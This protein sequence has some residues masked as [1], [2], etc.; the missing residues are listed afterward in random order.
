M[1]KLFPVFRAEETANFYDFLNAHTSDI[2]SCVSSLRQT[3]HHYCNEEMEKAKVSGQR[4]IELEK[5]ADDTRRKAEEALYEGV[6]IPFGRE[7]KYELLEA[8]DDLADKAEI[9]VR[10][11]AIEK[12]MIPPQLRAD[13]K[14]LANQVEIAT[15]MLGESVEKLGTDIKEA[16]KTATKVE[17]IRETARD[18]E[19]DILEH[20]LKNPIDPLNTILLKELITLVA[21]VADKAEDAA[22]R[23]ITLA[24]KY[25]S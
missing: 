25:K 15:N 23:V 17:L 6:I 8:L 12:P 2:K 10:L 11:A 18:H 21:K 1:V 3:V 7:D 16:I 13:I 20:L 5:Q 19:F 9:I 22:D 24:V 4:V 14:K